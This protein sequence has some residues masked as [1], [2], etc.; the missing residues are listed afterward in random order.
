M[1]IRI[2]DK[3]RMKRMVGDGVQGEE[4]GGLWRREWRNQYKEVWE[5]KGTEG[6]G[7]GE[8]GRKEKKRFRRMKRQRNRG[9]W[10]VRMEKERKGKNKKYEV[11]ERTIWE[12]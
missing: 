7:R 3:L 8:K 4:R 12:I 9:C 10:V 6:E 2:G 1:K 11:G 5:K